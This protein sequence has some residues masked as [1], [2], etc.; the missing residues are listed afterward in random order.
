MRFLRRMRRG[1]RGERGA[2]TVELALSLFLLLPLMFATFNYAYYFWIAITATEAAQLYARTAL[3]SG[4]AP[5][6]TCP[7]AISTPTFAA[8]QAAAFTA[9][10]NYIN[11]RTGLPT[12][13]V[14]RPASVVANDTCTNAVVGPPAV[15]FGWR[16]ALQVDFPPI[17]PM[18]LPFMPASTIAGRT[19]VTT[20][21]FVL[22]P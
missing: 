18:T 5:M 2:V 15:P 20:K 1:A 8:Q 12:S 10:Q 7:T 11:A 14:T 6:T 9:A 22:P 19:R 4:G 21:T 17:A 3:T 13:Y 16:I